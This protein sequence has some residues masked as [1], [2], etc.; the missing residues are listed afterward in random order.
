MDTR[1]ILKW[2][3]AVLAVV[4]FQYSRAND[5]LTLPNDVYRVKYDRTESMPDHLAYLSLMQNIR[6]AE[7]ES[8]RADNIAHVQSH[9]S[10]SQERANLF[11]EF[12]IASYDDMTATNRAIAS[13]MLCHGNRAAYANE[14]AYA[15]L[16]VIDDIKE[17][18]LRKHYKRALINFGPET[19]EQLDM[20]LAV[21]KTGSSHHKYDHKQVFEHSNE[22][23]E[24]VIST[25]CSV[26]AMY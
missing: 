14:E 10:L 15:L 6:L 9:L 1:Q 4:V 17:T 19:A 7:Q 26:L 22:S 16:D 24:S 20:W 13:R 23:V 21:I 2:T 3:T 12:V 8:S 11:L 18:N 5:T 25:A